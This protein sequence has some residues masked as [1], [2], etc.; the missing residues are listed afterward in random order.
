MVTDQQVKRL[1]KMD[2]KM[3]KALAQRENDKKISGI[4]HSQPS[5]KIPCL[6]L[7]KLFSLV[8]PPCKLPSKFKDRRLCGLSARG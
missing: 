2:P 6:T 1:F 7:Q 4:A 3:K 5:K 8:K